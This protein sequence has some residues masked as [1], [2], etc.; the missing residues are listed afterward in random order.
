MVSFILFTLL[1]TYEYTPIKYLLIFKLITM[2]YKA[3][4]LI[5][6]NDKIYIFKRL[7]FY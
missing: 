5:C 7:L 3:C 4:Y 2:S 6:L 1:A